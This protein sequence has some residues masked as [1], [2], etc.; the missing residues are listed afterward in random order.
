VRLAVIS[1]THGNRIALDAVLDDIARQGADATVHL[2]DT[3]SGPLDPAGTVERLM[4]QG[5]LTISGNHDRWVASGDKPDRID[6]FARERLSAE[7]MA[8]L[9]GLPQTAVIENLVFACHGTPRSD[10]EVWIDNFF[11]GRTTTLP[12][13]A[14]IAA[15]AEGLDFPVLLC[16]HT[17][18]PRV[19][20]LRD[21]RLV[22]NPGAVGLQF[23][24]GSPDAR[25]AIV[26]RHAG[27]WSVTLRSVPYDR[28]AAADQAEVNGFPGWRN[29]LEF[30]W[31]GPHGLF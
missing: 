7:H 30:G 24:H 14:E 23:T 22:V 11:D 16:G 13:E 27:D 2:G 1:D 10:T 12:S 15:R 28:H 19:V 5:M 29:A 18:I 3:V 17:H 6:R 8:W 31:D 26:E 9:A 21:G 20:R 4:A 25:Y